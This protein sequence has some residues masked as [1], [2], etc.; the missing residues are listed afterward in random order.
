MEHCEDSWKEAVHHELI[1]QHI[2]RAVGSHTKCYSPL[3]ARKYP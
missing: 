1:Y 2:I 3:F